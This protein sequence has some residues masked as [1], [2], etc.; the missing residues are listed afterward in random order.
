MWQRKITR[1]NHLRTK[2]RGHNSQ[3]GIAPI[4][5]NQKFNQGIYIVAKAESSD[6]KDPLST[7]ILSFSTVQ[8]VGQKDS[9]FYRLLAELRKKEIRRYLSC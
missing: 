8:W 3:K 2:P 5:Q 9:L 1:K 7:S 4:E 6:Q